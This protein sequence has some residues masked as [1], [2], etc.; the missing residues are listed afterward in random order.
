M[1]TTSVGWLVSGIKILLNFDKTVQELF[2]EICLSNS[3]LTKFDIEA[4]T[5]YKVIYG[6]SFVISTFI[7]KFVWNY[8]L[9][10]ST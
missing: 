1:G 4:V 6:F 10:F 3:G 7:N 8:L 5:L 2:S 9:T